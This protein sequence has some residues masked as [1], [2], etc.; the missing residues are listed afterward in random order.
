[1][2]LGRPVPTQVPGGQPQPRAPRLPPTSDPDNNPG[3]VTTEP[4]VPASELVVQMA[5]P[6]G[7]YRGPVSG[8]LYFPYKGKT[9]SIKSLDLLYQDTVLRL[10]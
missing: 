4:R 8:F 1:M 5:L 9:T 7:P 2:I 3:G 10:R 6:E